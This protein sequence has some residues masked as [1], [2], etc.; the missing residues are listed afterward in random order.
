[1]QTHAPHRFQFVE[2]LGYV[3]L[4]PLLLRILPPDASEL[5]DIIDMLHDP[6]RLWSPYGIRSLSAADAMWYGRANAPGDEPYWRGAV[7]I[8]INYL[9]LA[10]LHHYAHRLGP[11]RARAAQVYTE[12]RE[13]VVGNMLREW[14]RTGYFWEQ[15]DPETGHG[16]RTHPFNG[17]SSLV[18]LILAEKY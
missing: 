6:Q 3:S 2:H 10:G 1:M 12:L 9:V 8:N 17:W 15:Y 18:L 11:G 7:W 13:I 4:F 5:L 16:R 14:L